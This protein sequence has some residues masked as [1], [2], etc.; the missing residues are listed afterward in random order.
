MI[1][2]GNAKMAKKG[3][4]YTFSCQHKEKECQ[5]NIIQ[6]CAFE[7]FDEKVAW[8]YMLCLERTKKDWNEE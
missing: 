3:D 2:F 4:H 1:P 8:Q 6:T 7:L 5:G